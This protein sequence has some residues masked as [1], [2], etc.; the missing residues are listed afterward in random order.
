MEQQ[1]VWTVR[2]IREAKGVRRLV[3]LTAYDYGMARLVDEAGAALV[4][5]GDSLGMTVLGYKDTLPV[6]MED[7]LRHT[8]AVARGV[9]RAVVVTDLPFLSY[10]VSVAQAVENAGRCLK[11]AGASAVKIEGGVSR[12]ETIRAL[13]DNGIPVLGHVGLLPQSVRA[14]GGYR[15]RGREAEDAARVLDDARAVAQAGAFA[16]VL[17]GI[18]AALAA[19]ITASVDVPTIGIGAGPRCDGQILVLHDL[20]GLYGGRQPR[21][22]KRYADLGPVILEA[23]KRYADEVEAGVFPG[24]EHA[25]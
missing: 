3:A 10:Q 22:V 19:E 20:L 18:P 11:E 15:I 9:T 12:A 16:V 25:Y 1:T 14:G 4:L 5:V 7:M 13:V 6:T 23:L 8:A 24:P 21:F 17:E 2:S